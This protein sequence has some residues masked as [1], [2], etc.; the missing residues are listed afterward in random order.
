M[1]AEGYASVFLH[2][3]LS[4]EPFVRTLS[5]IKYYKQNR[6]TFDGGNEHSNELLLRNTCHNSAFIVLM[7]RVSPSYYYLF[8]ERAYVL[9]IRRV[10]LPM[11]PG[12]CNK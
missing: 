5:L 11:Y 12:T 3:L 8:A 9:S 6:P 7:I 1:P 4:I 10:R 2:V